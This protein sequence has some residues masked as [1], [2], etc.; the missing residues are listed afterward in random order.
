[1]RI[2]DQLTVHTAQRSNRFALGAFGH[3]VLLT[4]EDANLLADQCVA[5]VR[6]C[7]EARAAE[8]EAALREAE[9]FLRPGAFVRIH[10]EAVLHSG[11]SPLVVEWRDN[12]QVLTVITVPAEES[13]IVL[14]RPYAQHSPREWV[15]DDYLVVLSPQAVLDADAAIFGA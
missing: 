5:Y 11:V 12:G 10:R 1:M 14:V 6:R 7:E 13:E 8:V 2:N 15:M 3:L 4:E 9:R